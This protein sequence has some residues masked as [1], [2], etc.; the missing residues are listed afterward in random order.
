MTDHIT[1]S[2]LHEDA[3]AGYQA[4]ARSVREAAQVTTT[5]RYWQRT[6]RRPE[7]GGEMSVKVRW[8]SLRDRS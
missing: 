4:L 8:E 3:L 2:M 5:R 1:E 6:N 7:T